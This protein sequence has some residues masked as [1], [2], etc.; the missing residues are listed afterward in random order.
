MIAYV[1]KSRVH[2]CNV[3]QEFPNRPQTQTGYGQRMNNCN[4]N[5]CCRRR[6][7]KHCVAIF[8]I[9][10]QSVGELAF[11]IMTSHVGAHARAPPPKQSTLFV[12]VK[13]TVKIGERKIKKKTRRNLTSISPFKNRFLGNIEPLATGRNASSAWRLEPQPGIERLHWITSL[14]STLT[15]NS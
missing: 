15:A 3:F 5:K 12:F 14:I 6:G 7:K 4:E 8:R 13:G 9:V 11:W 2:L 10:S 1:S